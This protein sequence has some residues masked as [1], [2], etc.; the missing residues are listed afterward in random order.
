MIGKVVIVLIII[1][2]I[3]LIVIGAGMFLN[4]HD[5]ESVK[6]TITSMSSRQSYDWVGSDSEGD[7]IYL[8]R[9]HYYVQLKDGTEHQVSSGDYMKLKVGDIF[10]Y[11]TW[12]S[13]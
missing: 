1:A 8:W 4:T 10:T 12:V 13:K 7:S 11:Q 9:W 2:V 3:S 6:S 5:Y